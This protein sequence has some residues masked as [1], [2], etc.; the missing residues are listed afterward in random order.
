[1]GAYVGFDAEPLSSSTARAV[2]GLYV[3]AVDPGGP[4]AAAGIQVGDVVTKIDGTTATG[5][6]QLVEVTLRQ[7]PGTKVAFEVD[8]SGRRG[9]VTVVLGNEP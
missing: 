7:R 6:D 4:S 9:T 5:T 2:P 3:T 8:R 1:M